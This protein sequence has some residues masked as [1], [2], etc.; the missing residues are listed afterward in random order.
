MI[1][2][3]GSVRTIASSDSRSRQ[4][5]SVSNSRRNG[6][7]TSD[8]PSA[9]SERRTSARTFMASRRNGSTCR[10]L[11]SR[12]REAMT[13]ASPSRVAAASAVVQGRVGISGLLGSAGLDT[14]KMPHPALSCQR[15]DV[16]YPPVMPYHHGDLRR[17]LLDTALEAIAEHGPVAIS[18]REL[19]RRAG[20][21]HAAPTHHFR[22]KT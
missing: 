8:T 19:A 18:L 14:D 22:D 10:K 5:L 12:K 2:R 11:R 6:R 16:R 20:V 3:C 4:A 13:S 7:A 9:P 15:K 1:E 17:A 21:S